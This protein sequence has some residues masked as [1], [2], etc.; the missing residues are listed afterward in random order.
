MHHTFLWGSATSSHQVEGNNVHNDWWSWE[1]KGAVIEKSGIACDHY[2]RFNED[3][4]LIRSL[5]HT[6]HRFSLEW[7]RFEPKENQWDERAFDHYGEVFQS[8]KK[9]G[10]EPVV[11]LHHFTNPVWFHERGGWLKAE[12]NAYF[13]RYVRRVVE[14]YG[15]YVKFWITINE[16]IVY[17]YYS[18]LAGEWPPGI[19]SYR[20]AWKVFYHLLLAHVQAYRLIHDLYEQKSAKPVYVSLAKHWT[21]MRPDNPNSIADRVTVFSRDWLF[22]RLY[23][24]ALT[25]GFLFYPG[26]F[27]EYLPLRQSLDFLGINYYTLQRI[28]SSSKTGEWMG[29]MVEHAPGADSPVERNQMG[30]VIHPEGLS[31]LLKRLRPYHLPVLI[32]ENG[33]C[34][35]NDEQRVRYIQSHLQAVTSAIADGVS[36]AGYLYWSLMDNFEWAHGFGP[37]FGI[38]EVDYKTL[39]RKIRPSAYVLTELCRKLMAQP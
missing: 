35:E 20:A 27:C 1:Q 37:R 30:W 33:I 2:R 16:P 6:A 3:F 29:A 23:F 11:T 19:K 25:S 39:Q 18:Y 38:V 14:T 8:L 24:D 22:N 31:S 7:S 26:L 28:R 13:L 15:K 17:L 10:I 12:N 32:C 5:G 21:E 9:N 34:A 4:A 36:V